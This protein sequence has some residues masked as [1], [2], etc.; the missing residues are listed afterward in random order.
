M[1]RGY[2][3]LRFL[4]AYD[5]IRHPILRAQ[6]DEFA[7]IR[8]YIRVQRGRCVYNW[9]TTRFTANFLLSLRNR[10]GRGLLV[11]EME[12]GGQPLVLL[13]KHV[14]DQCQTSGDGRHYYVQNQL[15]K[16]L[17]ESHGPI[18]GH[19]PGLKNRPACTICV[20]TSRSAGWDYGTA[21]QGADY[22][23]VVPCV[24]THRH[25]PF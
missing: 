7:N 12:L 20:G 11:S 24:A 1:R 8:S 9:G 18:L 3:L 25:C 23:A 14:A 22:L 4:D 19:N 2:L 6:L 17:I 10:K 21:G 5:S 13:F 16:R 15:E